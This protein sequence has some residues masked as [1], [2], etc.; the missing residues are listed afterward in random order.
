LL[1]AYH[2]RLLRHIGARLPASL[3]PLVDAEDILEQT[4]VMAFRALG[5]FQ[6]RSERAFYRWLVTVGENQLRDA[7]K[8]QRRKKRGGKR[9]R[10]QRAPSEQTTT[11]GELLDRV[12]GDDRSPSTVAARNEGVRALQV[13]L[14]RLN[15]D[16][17]QVLRLSYLEAKS[18]DEVADEM[19]RSKDAVR[20][21][22]YRARQK[23]RDAMGQSSLW[24]SGD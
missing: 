1:F 13:A 14:A 8:A 20:G 15:D 19:G 23:L 4:Y 9:Q 22:L 11:K 7:I 12:C 6:P 18:L 24:F 5:Q 17:R 3:R 21:L 16:Y 10:V 2:D